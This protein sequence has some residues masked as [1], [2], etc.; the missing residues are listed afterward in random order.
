MKEKQDGDDSIGI[1]FLSNLDRHAKPVNVVR[2]SP[3][4]KL[5][6]YYKECLC[7]SVVG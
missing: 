7:A 4:G 1:E 3:N 2:F 6:I 5:C